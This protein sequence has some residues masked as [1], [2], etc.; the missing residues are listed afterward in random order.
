LDIRKSTLNKALKQICHGCLYATAIIVLIYTCLVALTYWRTSQTY[1]IRTTVRML[2][3]YP[4]PPVSKTTFEDRKWMI[5]VSGRTYFVFS[6]GWACFAAINR[7]ESPRIGDVAILS[8]S[9]GT[10]YISHHNLDAGIKGQFRPG[11]SQPKD[12][13]DFMNLSGIYW[14]K[15][16]AD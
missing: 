4:P 2:K 13:K 5:T 10:L 8:T 11:Q 16:T 1:W 14:E 3:S 7:D 9:E 6:N 12:L 15:Y